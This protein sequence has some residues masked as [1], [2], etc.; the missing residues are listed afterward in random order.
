MTA[1]DIRSFFHA[2]NHGDF[3]ALA[4]C[5][6]DDVRLDFPGAR[7]GG[8][9]QGRRRVLVFLRQNQRMFNCGLR[10]AVHWA[11][12]S[13]GRAVAQWTNTGTM[14]DGSVYQNCGVTVFRF[15]GKVIVAIQDYLD[16]ERLAS[17]WPR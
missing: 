13:D 9:F 14:R 17:S 11:A 16:T 8:S 1:D 4:D 15:D 12:V 10:F 7:F 2:L 6:S 5:M 3:D